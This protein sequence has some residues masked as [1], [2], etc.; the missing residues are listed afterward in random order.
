MHLDLQLLLHVTL[1]SS[2]ALLA[3]L[4]LRRALRAWLGATA[5]Y[6]I[7]AAVPLAVLAAVMPGRR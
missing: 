1:Y 4:V 2:A 6:A 3:C 5:A 7:W